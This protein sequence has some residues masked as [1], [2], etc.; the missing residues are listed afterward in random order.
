MC[1]ILCSTGAIIGLPN[2]RNYNLLHPLSEQLACD[3]FEF[4]MYSSWYEES[5]AIIKALRAMKLRFPVM[6]CEKHIGEAIS[7][8]DLATA[9]DLFEKN[10]FMAG[11]LGAKKLVIHLWDGYTSDSCFE[12]NLKA[13]QKLRELTDA[14]G[15]DLLVENIV[16]TTKDP[17]TRWQELLAAY[18]DMHFVFDT[19]MSEFHGQT[20]LL[21]DP[22]N[23][24]L[25]K[26]GHVRHYHVN[27]FGGQYMEWA[28]LKPLPIG[29]GHVDFK[30]FFDF[31]KRI[32]YNDTF[33]VES[34]A[35]DAQGVV[36]IDM[37][38]KQF[39]FIRE[40]MQG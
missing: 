32:G 37:L 5:D 39:R 7:K 21:Y 35:F 28:M 27:D 13:Y 20:G 10:V 11:E 4:M 29:Q 34:T 36:N 12:N 31:I 6:H 1:E 25:W 18:G 14:A 8:G 2:G 17:M 33:T 40:T 3:G 30:A 22:A 38:N 15:I 16:C 9:L 19:K 26:D 24:F 23:N